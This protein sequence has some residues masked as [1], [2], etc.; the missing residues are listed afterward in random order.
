MKIIEAKTFLVGAAW[1]NLILWDPEW[2]ER[3]LRKVEK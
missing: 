1:R 2:H 3:S